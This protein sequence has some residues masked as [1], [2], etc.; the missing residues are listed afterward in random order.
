MLAEEVE[1]ESAEQNDESADLND[2]GLDKEQRA[3]NDIDELEYA[4]EEEVAPEFEEEPPPEFDESGGDAAK[5][6]K[7]Q[8]FEPIGTE[9]DEPTF[10]KGPLPDFPKPKQTVRNIPEPGVCAA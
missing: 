4:D 7:R 1:A 10:G 3:S 8:S 2:D 9:E 6:Q 5:A